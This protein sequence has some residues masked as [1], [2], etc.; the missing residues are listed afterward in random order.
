MD[1]K[2][3]SALYDEYADGDILFHDKAFALF[4]DQR[5]TTRLMNG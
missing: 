3:P 2:T 5:T 1:K 4:P